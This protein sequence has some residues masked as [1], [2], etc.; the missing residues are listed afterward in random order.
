MKKKLTT[1]VIESICASI[2]AGSYIG[3]ACGRARVSKRSFYEWKK[4]GE[5]ERNE[6]RNTIYAKFL[7][8]VES[9]EADNEVMLVGAII[10]NDD[11]RAKME[12]LKRRYP[13]RWGDKN[14]Y[15]HTGANGEPLPAATIPPITII[16]KTDDEVPKFIDETGE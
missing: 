7:D 3:A 1:E 13:D 5:E 15:E 6:S 16:H 4:R 8:A 10:K 2:R 11:W 14:K 9:A 12:I